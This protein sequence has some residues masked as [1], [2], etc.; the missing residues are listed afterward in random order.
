MTRL[1]TFAVERKDS[2][3]RSIALTSHV[4]LADGEVVLSDGTRL[5]TTA[6]FVAACALWTADDLAVGVEVGAIV[7]VDDAGRA[8]HLS[9]HAEF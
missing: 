2:G 7:E 8:T 1:H 3:I 6:T 4:T 9:C 5:T